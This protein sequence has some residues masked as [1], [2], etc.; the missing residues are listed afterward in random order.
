[1]LIFKYLKNLK[2]FSIIIL[3][4]DT[5]HETKSHKFNSYKILIFLIAFSI[6]MSIVSYYFFNLTGIGH[7]V[8][9]GNFH[10]RTEEQQKVETLNEKIIFLATEIQ[11]L[12]STNQRLK[13]ALVLGD[14]VLADSLGVDLDSVEQYYEYPAEGNILSVILKFFKSEHSKTI[15]QTF[16][17]LPVNGY[18]S[19]EYE[20]EKGHMGLDIVVKENTPVYAAASGYVVFSGYT[21][22]EGYVIILNHSDG[23]MTIYK[24]CALLLKNERDAV[25]QGELIAQSGNSGLH[26]SGPHLHFEI[27]KDGSVIDPESVLINNNQGGF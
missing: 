8:L 16:F 4:D 10:I 25:E 15:S 12:K 3:P 1:M 19:R 13:Y 26:T 23:Y 6:F 21:V 24:H 27:W 22:D 20:P 11:K 14:T 17:I 9:P 2:N 7:K 18:I 5:S